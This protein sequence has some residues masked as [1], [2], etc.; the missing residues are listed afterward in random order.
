MLESY[1]DD[2]YCLLKETI[3]K[4]FHREPEEITVGNGSIELI[5]SFCASV[6]E[7]GD[8]IF[9][10]PPTFGEYEYSA[11]LAGAEC[12]TE[13]SRAKVRFLCNPNN[14]TGRLPPDLV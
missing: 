10:Q 6:L 13:P 14:P 7:P 12:T 9:L 2:T 3:G 4:I 5:R 1:P 11:R 8:R